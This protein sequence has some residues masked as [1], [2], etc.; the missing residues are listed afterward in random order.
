MQLIEVR[1][2]STRKLRKVF[3]LVTDL[4]QEGLEYLLRT[5]Q[6]AGIHACNPYLFARISKTTPLDGCT[7]VR[8]ITAMC[9]GLDNPQTIRS[10]LLRKYMAT[11]LQVNIFI[12]KNK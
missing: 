11:N 3:I 9:P 10:R 12:I 8:E 4:M 6:K 5:R 1:G 2:K 7:A